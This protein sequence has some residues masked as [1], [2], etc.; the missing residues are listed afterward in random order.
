MI[1]IVEYGNK[2]Y[3]HKGTIECVIIAAHTDDGAFLV[4]E[5]IEEG[6]LSGEL[7]GTERCHLSEM[8]EVEEAFI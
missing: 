3:L 4:A 7:F 2:V 6:D 8:D 5:K 1:D